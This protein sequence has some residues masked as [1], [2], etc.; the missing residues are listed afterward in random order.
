MKILQCIGQELDK[1]GNVVFAV[2]AVSKINDPKRHVAFTVIS[3]V[4]P[5]MYMYAFPPLV[6]FNNSFLFLL[7]NG[8]RRK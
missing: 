6:L 8:S 4:F 3:F 7:G 2:S 5:V 1:L